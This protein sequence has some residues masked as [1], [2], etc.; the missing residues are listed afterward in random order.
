[1]VYKMSDY[2][3]NIESKPEFKLNNNRKL[4]IFNIEKP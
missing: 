3:D 1:M 4:V 2:I